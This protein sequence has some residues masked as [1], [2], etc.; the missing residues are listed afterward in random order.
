M[1]FIQFPEDISQI[2]E[3]GLIIKYLRTNGRKG[4]ISAKTLCQMEAPASWSLNVNTSTASAD[5]PEYYLTENY[6][7]YNVTAATNGA[8]KETMDAAYNSYKKTIGTFDTL[9]TCRD[10]MNRIYQMTTSD[11]N[12]TNLVSNIV[13]SD[14]RDDINKAITLCT[15]T[16]RGIEYKNL[17]RK[18]SVQDA[19][20]L[21][22][23]DY[24][25]RNQSGTWTIEHFGKVFKITETDAS[26][27]VLFFARCLFNGIN[28]EAPEIRTDNLTHFDLVLYPFSATYNLN[29]KSEYQKSFKY[30]DSNLLEIKQNLEEN[31]TLA[32]NFIEP[33]ST[34]IAC[35]K[36]YLQLDAKITT[37]YKVTPIEIAEIEGRV[38]AKMY[39]LFNMRH[40][41]FGEEL[42]YD[43]I[44]AA[45][46]SADSRIKSVNLEDP[47]I[48]TKFCTVD[49]REYQTSYGI[50]N[51]DISQE[52]KT[53]DYYFNRLALNN[54]LAGRVPLFEYNTEFKAELSE[55]PYFGPNTAYNTYYP[56]EKITESSSENTCLNNGIYYVGTELAITGGKKVRDIKL[57]EH[58]VIQFRLPN[59][60]TSKTYPGYVNY[61]AK[62]NTAA[63]TN[64]IAVPA[65]MQPLLD[66]LLPANTSDEE[67]KAKVFTW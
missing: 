32:H 31:K 4:N 28:Y 49:G 39:E 29:T 9:V 24:K 44:L 46:E 7:V 53:G 41:D 16:D 37:L 42:P 18:L 2:I 47:T 15:F 12:P 20:Q 1:P 59:L 50:N 62:L 3:D 38:H 67:L 11:S 25:S 66:F 45:L 63:T 33:E 56:S 35:I 60:S 36:N 8:D 5:R 17:A 27:E 54:I 30:D 58:E 48:L 6:A 55:A 65:T 34:D 13:V 23:N 57:K 10:Y 40:I 22:L 52:H 61:F 51:T 21:S 43:S 19:I 64:S 26:T 14:I